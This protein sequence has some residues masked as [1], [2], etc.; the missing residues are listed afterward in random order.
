[1][2]GQLQAI[3]LLAHIEAVEVRTVEQIEGYDRFRGYLR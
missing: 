2:R 1:M 3:H